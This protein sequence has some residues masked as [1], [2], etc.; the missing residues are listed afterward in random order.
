MQ[1]SDTSKTKAQLLDELTG[2]R[3]RVAEFEKSDAELK[4]AE[5]ELRRVGNIQS[6]ILDNS[7]IGICFV[8]NRIFEWVNPRLPEM[9]GLPLNQV[10]GSSTRIIYPSDETCEEIGRRAY[11]ALGGG[12][13]FEF[14]TVVRRADGA[15]FIGRI[16]GKAVDP[17]HPQ[18]G[19]IWIFEE[20]TKR[21]QAEEAL[22]ETKER[23]RLL[24][25]H[26]PDGIVIIDPATARPLEFNE[27]AH[28]QLGYSREEFAGMSIFDVEAAETPEETRARIAGVIRNGRADFE[29]RQRTRHGDIRDVHVTAQFTEVLGKPLYHCIWRDI[30]D[31]KR[32]EEELKERERTHNTLIENLPGFVYRCR[33]DRN[34]TMEYISAGCLTVTGYRPEDFINNH[35]LA[36]N[37]ILLPEYVE[38]LWRKWQ[39]CIATRTPFEAEYQFRTAGGEIA[40]AWEKGRGVFDDKGRLQFL[41][42]YITDVTKRKR[43]EREL[44]EKEE[45]YRSLFDHSTDAI[46]LTTPDGSVLDANSAACR[47]F[48]RTLEEIKRVGRTGL[49]DVTDPRLHAALGKRELTGRGLAEVI[50]L[51]ADGEKFPAEVTSAIFV[52]ASGRQKTSMIIRDI[53]ERKRAEEALRESEERFRGMME[54]SPLSIQ[55]ISPQGDVIDVNKAFEKLWGVKKEDLKGYN[56][57]CDRQIKALGFMPDVQRALAGEMATT[58]TVEYDAK[59]TIGVGRKVVAQGVFYPVLDA[60]GA[61]RYVILLHLD[62]TERRKAEEDLKRLSIAIEQAAEDIVITN[63]AGVIQ[64]VNP[65]FERVTGYSREE[66]IGRTPKVLKSGLHG[67]SFYANLWDTI[68]SGRIWKG[69]ITN[70]RKDG[71][72]IQE[73]AT[74]SPL[75][76]STGKLTGFVALKRDVTEAV[77][78]EV[79]LRQAQKM[80]AI[81]TLAGG[82]AHDFNNILG[83]MMGYTELTKLKTTDRQI[84]PYLEQILRACDRSRELVKQILT[85]SRRQ[86]QQRIP[87]AVTPIVKEALKLL[88]SSI[89]STVTIVPRYETR[90]DVVFGD[91]TQIQQVLMN[92]CTNAVHAMRKRQGVLEIRLGEGEITA[93]HPAFSPEMKEGNYLQLVVSDTGE[94]IDPTIKD[95]IFDPFFTTKSAGEGTGLGLSV[96]YGIVKDHGGSIHLESQ[97]GK[98]TVF[99]VYLPLTDVSEE[100]EGQSTPAIPAGK[101]R[102]LY[103]DDEEAVAVPVREMLTSLG[104][105][106]SVWFSSRDALGAFQAHPERFDLVITDMTMPNMT[107]DV[108]AGKMLQIRPGIP[109]ILT[110]GFSE[111]INEEEA[112]R[113]GIRK[114]LM[115]PVSLSDLART[116][117]ELIDAGEIS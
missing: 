37:D 75:L 42:G 98:G 49:V 22:H 74:I 77:R 6:L 46:L 56:M 58:P 116:V 92:L 95:K 50:M 2:L 52:D 5:N 102:I 93:G 112:S 30:T 20:I 66:V 107:G 68:K 53:T 25:E 44:R 114:F 103:V 64:Y 43:A 31:R 57:L 110:T 81:G 69:R 4:R 115:K 101:G 79:Q 7:V 9:L 11:S 96:V 63:T 113:I 26:S 65:A 83:A 109:I 36:Y 12:E 67:P 85:F 38:P 39:E 45:R 88:R 84:L 78:M 21:K 89:P 100:R 55:V 86:E 14:E 108:L 72:L 106:V 32:A 97:P 23:Y 40:W 111:R 29:T 3:R 15:G 48:G 73:D 61:V 54:Q 10:Q 47:M 27:T 99:T 60:R 90:H 62:F 33:N 87:A 17:D 76:S 16:A 59:D 104:Y 18:D 71:N 1:M 80:E 82:I 94:G 34:W 117:K 8:R 24:F 28:R 13:W 19:S 35:K 91:P 51:R 105:E 70:R 41:E